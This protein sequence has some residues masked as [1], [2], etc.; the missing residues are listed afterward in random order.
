VEALFDSSNDKRAHQVLQVFF[1]SWLYRRDKGKGQ[2]I[3]P[4]IY[5]LRSLY[6]DSFS[7][8][9]T[10]GSDQVDDFAP[11]EDAFESSLKRTIEEIFDPSIPF[12]QT[13]NVGICPNCKFANICGKG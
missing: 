12:K 5:S 4:G 6:G 11:Y 8:Q 7:P 1:Y 9:T 2:Q 10:I 3:Q 13:D